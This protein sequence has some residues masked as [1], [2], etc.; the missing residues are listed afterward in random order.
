[1]LLAIISLLI[2]LLLGGGFVGIIMYRHLRIK[3]ANAQTIA[4]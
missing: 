1:M 2:G 4:Q 3:G